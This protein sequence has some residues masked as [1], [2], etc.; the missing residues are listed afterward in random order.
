MK[1][2]ILLFW[3]LAFILALR[4]LKVFDVIQAPDLEMSGRL[5]LVLNVDNLKASDQERR[6]EVDVD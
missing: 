4:N 1:G 6:F 2:R 5:G 3:L